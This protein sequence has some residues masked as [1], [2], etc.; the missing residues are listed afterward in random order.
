MNEANAPVSGVSIVLQGP[1]TQRTTTDAHGAFA[2]TGVT[3][4]I[5]TLTAAK[6]G[7]QTTI[8]NDLTLLA[9]DTS[10]VTVHL[11]AA[12]FSSLQTIASVRTSGRNAINTSTA[13]V[14]VVNTQAFQDQGQTQVTRVLSQVPGLQISFPS[15]S[16]NAAAPGAITV[17]NIRNATSYETASLID[18]H[19][20]SVGQYGDNVTTFL[21]A[22]MFQNIEVVKGPGADAPEV[23]NAIGGTTNFRTK[24]PTAQPYAQLLF[25]VSN[26]G[27]TLSNFDFRDS[28]G[29]FGF[30]IDLASNNDPSALNGKQVYYSPAGGVISTGTLGDQPGSTTIGSTQ[31][32][33]PTQPHLLACCYT[34]DGGLYQNAQLFKLQYRFS[35]STRMTVSFMGSQTTADQNGN[36]GNLFDAT[37]MP[38]P[39]Y[40]GSIPAGPLQYAS[41]YPGAPQGEI[42]NQPMFQAEA[43]SSIG[44]NAIIARFYTA[45]VSRYQFGGTDPTGI[46]FNTVR[47]YG[48]S[49]DQ[50]NGELNQTFNGQ[51]ANVGYSDFYIEPELDKLKGGSLELQHPLGS[52]GLLSLSADRT[53][54]E[55]TDYVIAPGGNGPE[56]Y[57]HSLLPGSSQI[58]TTYL[59]R[60]QFFV[61]PKLNVT[62]SDYFN[63][64][65]TTYAIGCAVDPNSGD[66][67]KEA[68]LTGAGVDLQTAKSTHNDPRLA[69]VYRPNGATAVRFA[70]GSS[71]AP[72]FLGLYSGINGAPTYT[73]GDSY[74]LASENNQG[75]K[76]ET[77]FG[78]DLGFDARVLDPQT[79][80]SAD[81]Y[82]TN[83]FNRFF[84]QTINTGLTCAQVSCAPAPSN[85]GSIPVFNN[86][87]TNISNAR[88]E[89]IE[90]SMRRQPN[91]GLGYNVSASLSKGYYYNLPA[92][93][94]CDP[95]FVAVQ[96][97]PNQN[98]NVVAGQNTNGLPVGQFPLNAMIS[99]NGNMRIPYS[100]ANADITYTFRNGIF[101]EFGDTYY[102]KN[103]SLNR[104]PFGIAY[105][106]LRVP[107]SRAISLQIS[108][109]NI[110]N[111]YPGLLPVWGAGVP[112]DLYGGQTAATNG[113]V[114]GPATYRLIMSTKLP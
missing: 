82:L 44:N 91:V 37:F 27:G 59:A 10:T 75:L 98:L 35:P 26:H 73:P 96:P 53:V 33:L 104:P 88:F 83:L 58:L 113:N 28:V 1:V 111:A 74:A 114:L 36:T 8:E 67:T 93:F 13:S 79:V 77:A 4:G 100:Q 81:A 32:Q 105:A 5:Y 17:P 63:T 22:F 21:N 50:G 11:V 89:G 71:I 97:C 85:P 69:L 9:G 66:C 70:M 31:S 15:N 109:D 2:F 12:T 57:Y 106:S 48:T 39:S 68:N 55:S 87:S 7:Y 45:T 92:G 30:V 40:T 6:A 56:T 41:I 94:Y 110:F 108:G 23:N 16:A 52:N 54:S 103:N 47:L 60:G 49:S 62:L 61:G 64:Y 84:S 46:D 80:V 99:Y 42:N 3:P 18:G 20:I 76:P 19:R 112:I 14:S 102:G 34:L 107:V 51:M 101:A 78:Y 24:D 38:D 43:S 65:N 90:F 25:G 86:M 29:K 72:Q 95:T